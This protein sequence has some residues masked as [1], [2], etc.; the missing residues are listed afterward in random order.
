MGKRAYLFKLLQDIRASYWFLPSLL[1]LVGLLL[2]SGMIWV[3]RN[4]SVVPFDVPHGWL[5]TQ[6]DGARSMLA[7]I[8]QSI[9]GVT[10]VMFSMTLV[11]VSFASGNFGPRLIGNFMRDRG[12]QWSLGILIATFVYALVVLRTVQDGFEGGAAQFVPHYSL[13]L[14]VGL[15]LLCVFT[16]IYFVH[17]VPETINV[18]QISAS[19]GAAL[20][21]HVR[22]LIDDQDD[23]SRYVTPPDRA[24]DITLTAGASGYIQT[25]NFSQLEKLADDYDL[26][27]NL[28]ASIGAFVTEQT[29]VFEIWIGTQ[30]NEDDA[31]DILECYAIGASR[32]ENQNPTFLAEQL[33]EM[34]AR[35][36]SPGVNDPYTA[37]DCLNRL[38]AALTVASTYNGGIKDRS[39][40]RITFKALTFSRLFA[41]SFPLCRQY[42][43]PDTLVLEHA[44]TLLNDLTNVVRDEDRQ[45]IEDEITMLNS[46]S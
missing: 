43:K 38:A 44:V 5:D 25:V 24:P 2:A 11:A 10:G 18:S 1:V 22:G 42:I 33:V 12:N 3:D 13:L 8:A 17:H 27:V 6:A 9:I 14:A 29:P 34:I 30:E 20:E 46:E 28:A 26:R 39:L 45:V 4:P 35:A 31:I 40:P 19:I 16:L 36:L 37:K 32:T 7:V 41:A 23:K 21:R 15:T